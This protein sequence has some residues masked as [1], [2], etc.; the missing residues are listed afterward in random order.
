MA[1]TKQVQKEE[2][3]KFPSPNEEL[4][5]DFPGFIAVMCAMIGLWLKVS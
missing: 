2:L 1:D 3:F 4:D 5:F